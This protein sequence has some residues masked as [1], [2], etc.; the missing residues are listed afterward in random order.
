MSHWDFIT[1]NTLLKRTKHNL[2]EVK[3]KEFLK[4]GTT[5]PQEEHKCSWALGNLG[6]GIRNQ[7]RLIF[8]PLCFSQNVGFTAFPPQSSNLNLAG[9]I[10][11]CRSLDSHLPALQPRRIYVL[12]PASVQDYLKR[13]LIFF[14]SLAHPLS[15]QTWSERKGTIQ[16]WRYCES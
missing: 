15:N 4:Y 10:S 11:T 7:Q 13:E 9:H 12:V 8:F 1:H 2:K 6:V 3:Q 14:K 5:E 16:I